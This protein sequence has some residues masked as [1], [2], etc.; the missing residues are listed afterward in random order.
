MAVFRILPRSSDL[1]CSTRLFGLFS[2]GGLDW[3]GEADI[4]LT[5]RI[6]PSGEQSTLRSR[7]TSSSTSSTTEGA[8]SS[9]FC[10]V[11]VSSLPL[12][13]SSSSS[14]SSGSM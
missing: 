8:I 1:G 2:P 6:L 4:M 10:S 7:D 9:T 11:R 5:V 13:A 3:G 12:E 14:S